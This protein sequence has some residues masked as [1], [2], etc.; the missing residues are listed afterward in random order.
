M[1]RLSLFRSWRAFTLIELLVVIAIIAILIGLL[2]PA[3]QKVREAAARIQCS[4][5]L[6]QISMATI[7]CADTNQQLLPPATGIYPNPNPSPNNGYGPTFFH[8]LP[9]L[10]QG[11][12]YNNSL[13]PWDF[14]GNNGPA[15][16]AT[17]FP[18]GGLATYSP[19]TVGWGSSIPSNLKIYVCPSDPTNNASNPSPLISY[20]TNGQVMPVTWGPAQK[21]PASITDGTSNTIFYTELYAACSAN[22]GSMDW[23]TDIY[24]P[25]GT[26]AGVSVKGV[27]PFLGPASLFLV[28][29][30]SPSAYCA[31]SPNGG[32]ANPAS[33]GV[34]ASP[35]TGGINVALG[36][37]SVRF[38]PQGISG[39]TWWSAMTPAGGEVLGPDW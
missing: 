3:V 23:G 24:D 29:V 8:I 13:Q 32:A 2:L 30:P 21:Y 33:V 14:T 11:N 6:K 16:G 7:N 28:R 15:Q 26:S 5:N 10:E 1:R 38:V 20:A 27:N 17:T 39:V 22:Y 34:A 19:T 25:Q 9:Y 37:G 31:S 12:A 36:D 4:N 18:P 35:H